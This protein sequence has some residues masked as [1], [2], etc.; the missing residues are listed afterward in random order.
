MRHSIVKWALC[1]SILSL[2]Q[3]S[4]GLANPG[5]VTLHIVNGELRDVLTGLAAAAG[6]S[7]VTD[8]AV[9]GKITV[10]L[11]NIP[12]ETAL[13]IITKAKSLY[14]HRIDNIIVVS[15][16]QSNTRFGKIHVF[17]LKYAKPEDVILLAALAIGDTQSNAAASQGSGTGNR[18]ATTDGG[19]LRIDKASN[20][21]IVVGTDA[22]A[23]TVQMLLEKIDIPYRQVSLEAQ[24]VAISKDASKNLGVEWDWSKGPNYPEYD[25]GETAVTT[26]A[27][28]NP[29]YSGKPGKFI[30]DKNNMVGTIRFG[31]SPGGYPYEMYYQ[32]KVN[33]L[34]AQDKATVL[35][36][37]K[38]MALNGKEAI[39]TIGS[40]IPVPVVT[41]A[42][43][44]TTTS[45]DYKEAGI[46]L[47]YTPFINSDGDIAA[48]VH[49]EV[50]MPSLVAELKAYRFD[51]RSADTEVWLKDGETMVI[52][53][54]IGR[55]EIQSASKVPGLGELPVIGALFRSN[56]HANTE[57]ELVIFLTATI[58]K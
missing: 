24:V 34:I 38:I 32:F 8:E 39:I 45:V 9:Q 5:A 20:S 44:V 4:I 29:V 21:L 46:I 17:T 3:T 13:D 6:V 15:S 26:D 30:R 42:D 12:F 23:Q 10:Q 57:N 53:G 37:P 48:K 16:Q 18:S 52:G 2:L 50:S 1:F 49:I 25:A 54:L 19:R 11:D 22:E 35:S 51:T 28:G 47:K 36:R 41:T 40:Q 33:A 55:D 14:C 43:G 58:V 31:K 56:T 27:N 7:I